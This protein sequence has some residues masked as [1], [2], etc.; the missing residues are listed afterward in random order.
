MTTSADRAAMAR[1][2]ARDLS[3][4]TETK[5]APLALG[6]IGAAGTFEGY[7]S[8]FGI[9]DL[10]RDVVD[11][12]AFAQSLARR[13]PAQVK[14][15]WQHDPAE[16]IGAWLAIEEDRIGLKVKGRLNLAVARAREILALMREGQ[17]DGLSIGFRTQRATTDRKTGL[18]HLKQIDLWEI[19]LV[20]FPMLPQARVSAVKRATGGGA[21]NL[22]VAFDSMKWRRDAGRLEAKLI[23]TTRLLEVRYSPDQPRDDAGRWAEA[24]PGS[25]DVLAGL[26]VDICVAMG[27]ARST[28]DFGNKWYTVEYECRDG[29]TIVRQGP[30][31]APGLI[32][33]PR[34]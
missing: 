4:A 8:L 23:Q 24:D 27:I 29:V 16:P 10:G 12:G 9:A 22:A 33:D 2:L 26:V 3:R 20:T 31:E 18:R 21:A 28:D 32:R 34:N 30:G 13:G 14:M 15:L 6:A 7:A 11:R 5:R 1:A 25:S 19:S 17:V